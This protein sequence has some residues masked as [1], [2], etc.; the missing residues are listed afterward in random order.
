MLDR[1]IPRTARRCLLALGLTA[2][3]STSACATEWA[4]EPLPQ[5]PRPNTLAHVRVTRA[6]GE[7][8]E[9][10]AMEVRGDSLYGARAYP[11]TDPALAL[12]LSDVAR[13]ESARP[14]TPVPALLGLGAALVVFRWVVLP[15]LYA[16]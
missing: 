16:D 13:I 11:I 9:L 1:S 2:L 15:A 10:T 5:G 3:A 8:I 6:S 14:S 12:P 7:T 4:T